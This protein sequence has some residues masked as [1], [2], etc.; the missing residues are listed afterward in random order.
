MAE[1]KAKDPKK[2]SILWLSIIALIACIMLVVL[3]AVMTLYTTVC[4]Q[5]Y[6]KDRISASGYVDSAYDALCENLYSLGNGGGF[7]NE[8]MVAAVSKEQLAADLETAVD[9]MF[10]GED[11]YDE[12]D[13]VEEEA[14]QAMKKEADSRGVTVEGETEKAF[15][16]MSE[17]VQTEYQNV[18]NIPL[19]TQIFQVI[20]KVDSV[21]WIAIAV[22]ALFTA[23]SMLLLIRLGKNDA[24]LGVNFL[25]FTLLGAALV[26]LFV[27]VGLKP[28]LGLNRFNMGSYALRDLVDSYI[29]G[30]FGRFNVFA[31]VYAILAVVLYVAMRFG[32][33]STPK[34]K[35][36]DDESAK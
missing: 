16:L 36:V 31:A 18:A 12:Y 3:A 30:V 34:I 5:S 4:R 35:V 25:S 24:R 9:R 13:A 6:M 19:A 28:I 27:G 1:K 8:T 32:D 15:R 20:S 17:A 10:N 23:V 14:F 33:R 26:C 29:S 2:V 21:I 22:C 11:A 7:S